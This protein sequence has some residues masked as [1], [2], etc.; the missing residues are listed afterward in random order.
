MR[1]KSVAITVWLSEY[2]LVRFHR[3]EP[4][5]VA[6]EGDEGGAF[7]YASEEALSE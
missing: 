5:R 7:W 2:F 3:A 4:P 6:A 1:A